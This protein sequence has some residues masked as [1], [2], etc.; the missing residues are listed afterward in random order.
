MEQLP[1]RERGGSASK[2]RR[3]RIWVFSVKEVF[4]GVV[5]GAPS[6][7]IQCV[8]INKYLCRKHYYNA[9]NCCRFDEIYP[10]APVVTIKNGQY[11]SEY[12][13]LEKYIK[14]H[15]RRPDRRYPHAV[16]CHKQ[17]V[18]GYVQNHE[19]ERFRKKFFIKIMH[20][21]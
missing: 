13:E 14:N 15:S 12:E 3:R 17:R 19:P 21:F 5:Q 20:R 8:R 1:Y 6:V 11:G 2:V 4:Y 10:R 7:H 18:D 9:C 16:F